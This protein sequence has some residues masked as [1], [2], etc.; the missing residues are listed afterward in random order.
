[1]VTLYLFGNA[2]EL[3]YGSRDYLLI[4]FGAILGGSLLALYVHRHH[5]YLA[6]G[7]SGGVCGMIF[8]Y[9]LLFPGSKISMYFIPVY[10]PGWLYA[11]GYL[12]ISF[13][14]LKT[15]R[16]NVG[17]DAHIGGAIVGLL[18]AAGL[19]TEAAKYNW[20][21]FLAVLVVAAG[22]LGYIWLN[23]MFLPVEAFS[24]S[25]KSRW[26]SWKSRNRG[27]DLPQ[28]KQD[29][30]EVDVILDKVSKQGIQGLSAEE[31]QRLEAMSS[32]YRRR[33]ESKKPTSG[34][35]I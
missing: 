14:G 9:I 15:G 8:A 28:Y 10:V 21:M 16:G 25:R 2:V 20:K 35:A 24:G 22:L 31:K 5:D 27:A 11:I 3:V 30:V 34:L 7:A 33:E 18:I 12:L 1:M 29:Q 13:F 17:H 26:F 32:K 23:P 6:Y 19:H 4:Y